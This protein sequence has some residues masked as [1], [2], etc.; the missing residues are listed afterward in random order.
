[1]GILSFIYPPTL[2]EALNNFSEPKRPFDKPLPLPI[3][4]AYKIEGIGTV[5][6]GRVE[7][8]TLKPGMLLTIG[9]GSV[10]AECRTVQKHHERMDEAFPGDNIGFC[11]KN[12][13]ELKRGYVASDSKNDP[14]REAL[15]FVV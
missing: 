9:P 7:T 11:V 14:C 4:D 15:S 2:I 10:T 3:Q 1:M 13:K 5:A 8:G 6:V 12:V